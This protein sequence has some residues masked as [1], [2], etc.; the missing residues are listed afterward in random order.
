MT[1]EEEFDALMSKLDS[2]FSAGTDFKKLAMA[3][4]LRLLLSS[5][6]EQV[7]NLIENRCQFSRIT[8]DGSCYCTKNPKPEVECS[9]DCPSYA[10][11]FPLPVVEATA[12]SACAYRGDMISRGSCSCGDGNVY[13]CNHPNMV[14]A[15][16][17]AG[18][19]IGRQCKRAKCTGYTITAS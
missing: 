7:T 9:T 18:K 2:A 8:S 11:L 14:A 19:V 1:T 15:D 13:A 6:K 10:G 12:E 3:R 17:T 16:G 4:S 5:M